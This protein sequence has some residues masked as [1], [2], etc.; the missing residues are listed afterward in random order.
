MTIGSPRR[1]QPILEFQPRIIDIIDWSDPIEAHNILSSIFANV[2]MPNFPTGIT[3]ENVWI[4]LQ[5]K[6]G[7]H[8]LLPDVTDYENQFDGTCIYQ[9]SIPKLNFYLKEIFND[10]N[11]KYNRLLLSLNGSY[12]PLKPYDI[13]EEESTADKS[14]KMS[15]TYGEHTD[16]NKETSM[17]STTQ[18]PAGQ[19]VVGSHT[20]DTF[21]ENTVSVNF[22]G[23][24][25]ES[26]IS[27]MRHIKD[28]RSGNL[29]NLA[30]A[31]IIEKEVKLGR[32]SLFDII[33]RDITDVICYKLFMSC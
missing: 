12:D 4:T 13:M 17:D 32:F 9:P 1:P 2:T 29:G 31:D 11:P 21:Y 22:E 27:S 20:D 14:S 30:Y 23:S 6:F 24:S 8:F 16:T 33:C 7:E 3:Y 5:N 19:T 26:G 10:N 15:T 18:Q 28:R 25:F